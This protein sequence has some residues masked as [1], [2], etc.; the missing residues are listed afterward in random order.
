MSNDRL[1]CPILKEAGIKFPRLVSSQDNWWIRK[2]C[3]NCPYN[4][5]VFDGEKR[6]DIQQRNQ[7]IARLSKS[8]TTKELAEMFGLS[9]STINKVKKE[10]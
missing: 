2:F 3:F 6:F 7:E 9:I 4:R 8:K 1:G 10:E 5:C